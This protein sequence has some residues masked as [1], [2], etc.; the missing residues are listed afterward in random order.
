MT[1]YFTSA[2]VSNEINAKKIKPADD[3]AM[4]LADVLDPFYIR[5][6]PAWKRAMDIIGAIIGMI[7]S[8]P[9]FIIVPL[10]IKLVSPGPVFFKQE[11]IGYGGRKFTF[12][13]FR[14]M[15]VDADPSEHKQYYAELINTCNDANDL[16]KMHAETG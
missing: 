2:A 5:K 9:I 11:R 12:I 10:I 7:F 14:T 6:I 15:T 4:K 8:A 16:P 3:P 1:T 13:K